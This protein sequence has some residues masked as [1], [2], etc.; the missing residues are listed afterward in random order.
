MYRPMG[1]LATVETKPI[2]TISPMILCI[3]SILYGLALLLTCFPTH[4]FCPAHPE[5][6]SIALQRH[7]PSTLGG[8][9][10]RWDICKSAY[11][12][13]IRVDNGPEF[14][15]KD[16]DLWAYMHGVTLNFSRPG[17]PTDNAFV[18]AFNSRVRQECLNAYW[19]LS[20]ADARC[21]IEAW[22]IEYNTV[23]PHS[24]LGHRSPAEYAE[25]LALVP[26]GQ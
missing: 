20:L 10:D 5:H 12:K 6:Q 18:E 3:I 4:A 2:R 23:R 14:V 7:V 21:K 11:P 26:P 9:P 19:F 1:Q 13:C 15:S 24:S 8:A 25:L 16:L 22:R 17:K